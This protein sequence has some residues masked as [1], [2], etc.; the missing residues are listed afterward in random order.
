MKHR[1]LLLAFLLGTATISV[2]SQT[3]NPSDCYKCMQK[4]AKDGDV[5]S[6]LTYS[7]QYIR[8]DPGSTSGY[9][10]YGN[11]NMNRELYWNALSGFTKILDMVPDYKQVYYNRSIAFGAVGFDALQLQDLNTALDLDPDY[12]WAYVS[13]AAYYLK[14]GEIDAF[15]TDT[16]KAISLEPNSPYIYMNIAELHRGEMRYDS[17]YHYLNK[18]ISL[19][20]DFA[21]AYLNRAS[22]A[23]KLAMP[24]AQVKADANKALSVFEKRLNLN[25]GNISTLYN[26]ATALSLAGKK[27]ESDHIFNSMFAPLDEQI[28]LYPEAYLLVYQ[29]GTMLK[30]VGRVEE[31]LK[32]MWKAEKMNPKCPYMGWSITEWQI[33]IGFENR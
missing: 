3:Q 28:K 29:K 16:K 17:A 2:S 12:A 30:E 19:D 20:P 4:A 27:T 5:L 11:A 6:T 31:A 23:E 26:K 25:P 7:L 14:N 15:W 33:P 32:E 24:E 8:L 21:E 13:R 9:F 22:V 18:V 10:Y 1:F